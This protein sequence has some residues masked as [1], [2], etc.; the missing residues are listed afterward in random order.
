MIYGIKNDINE[1]YNLLF[2]EF[3]FENDIIH[4]IMIFTLIK[5][6]GMMMLC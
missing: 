5:L 3:Y 2:N 4:Q 6:K 1:E